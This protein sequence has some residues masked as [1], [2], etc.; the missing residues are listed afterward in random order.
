MHACHGYADQLALKE[1][2]QQSMDPENTAVMLICLAVIL[3]ILCSSFT[4]SI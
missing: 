1:Q 3:S 4:C 2:S